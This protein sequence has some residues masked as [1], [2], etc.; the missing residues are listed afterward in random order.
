MQ[1]LA[2]VATFDSSVTRLEVDERRN[3]VVLDTEMP[4]V[5]N[6]AKFGVGTIEAV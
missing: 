5:G 2:P 4:Y 6:D 3:D 1:P